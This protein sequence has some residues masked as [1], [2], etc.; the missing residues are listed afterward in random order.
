MTALTSVIRRHP[1]PAA[2]VGH[3]PQLG[4]RPALMPVPLSLLEARD[5]ELGEPLELR[6]GQRQLAVDD[7]DLADHLFDVDGHRHVLPLQAVVG[8]LERLDRRRR[9]GWR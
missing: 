6:L 5:H 7:R 9:S 8:E 2:V 3:R 4:G 1:L